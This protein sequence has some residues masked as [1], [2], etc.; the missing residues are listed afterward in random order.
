VEGR[1]DAGYSRIVAR[2]SEDPGRVEVSDALVNSLVRSQFAH[3]GTLEVGR[4]YAFDDHVTIRLGD[5]LCANLPTVRGPDPLIERSGRLL[6]SEA[7]H[8]TFPAGIPILT[9]KP[10]PDYPYHWE[11]ARW[12]PGSN[13][14]IVDLAA[15]AGIRLGRALREVHRP[16]AADAPPSPRA[17]TPLADL[18]SAW[19]A[20][21]EALVESRGPQGETVDATGLASIWARGRDAAPARATTWVHGNLDPRYVVSDHGRFGGICTWFTFGA[22]DPAADLGA[23]CLLVPGVGEEAILSGYGSIDDA[24]EDRACAFRLLTCATYA[25]SSNPFLWR[26]GW[27]RLRDIEQRERTRIGHR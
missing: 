15:D 22:G 6:L 25:T 11:I 21:L 5:R 26:L 18:D 9:G 3:L 8:W 2:L 17:V 4:R 24:M 10:T 16:A 1:C 23:A 14:T 27:D 7:A 13:A 12:L 19:T 20:T